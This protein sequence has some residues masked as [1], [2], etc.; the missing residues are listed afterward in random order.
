MVKKKYRKIVDV[1]CGTGDM[2]LFGKSC[3]RK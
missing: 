3:K 2:I 1:A